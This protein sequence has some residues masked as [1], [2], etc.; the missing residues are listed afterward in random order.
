MPELS[1]RLFLGGS[2][3]GLAAASGFAA[4]PPAGP[5]R[6]KGE[7]PCFQ[8]DKLLLTWQRDP[9]TTMTVQWIGTPGETSDTTVYYAAEKNVSCK[10][11]KTAT[12]PYPK[13]RFEVFRAELT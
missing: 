6:L 3:A 1:R 11:K 4:A 8:P 7:G 10:A 2:L 5:P 9:T 12:K 13:T